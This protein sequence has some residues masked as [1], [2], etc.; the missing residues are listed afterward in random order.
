MAATVVDEEQN[1]SKKSTHKIKKELDFLY[2]FEPGVAESSFGIMV[3]EKAG[4]PAEVLDIAT[5]KAN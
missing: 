1:I 2:K 5:R 4:L 3:A